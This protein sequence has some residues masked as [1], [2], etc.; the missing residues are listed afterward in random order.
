MKDFDDWE[1]SRTGKGKW[2]ALGLR[3]LD[4]KRA[5]VDT[6]FLRNHQD[7]SDDD[8]FFAPEEEERVV[9][10]SVDHDGS[11]LTIKIDAWLVKATATTL[12]DNA[13]SV[14]QDEFLRDVLDACKDAPQDA[15]FGFTKKQF[16][17]FSHLV[18]TSDEPFVL[19][20]KKIEKVRR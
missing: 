7:Q 16:T 14:R 12:L 11:H 8:F 10:S 3:I 4:E 1:R 13:Q 9:V 19:I 15:L 18:Q 5:G 6:E 17:W 20:K 2:R